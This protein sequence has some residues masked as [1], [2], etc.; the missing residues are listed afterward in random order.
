VNANVLMLLFVTV[1]VL[2]VMLIDAIREILRTLK[3]IEARMALTT[4]TEDEK[5]AIRDDSLASSLVPTHIGQVAMH[6]EIWLHKCIQERQE[7]KGAEY[8]E[9]V[10]WQRSIERKR[11]RT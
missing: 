10:R 3:R 2:F 9:Q 11:R 1:T 8:R 6:P 4:P 5:I 7:L